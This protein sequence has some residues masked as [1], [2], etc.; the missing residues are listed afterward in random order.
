MGGT[1]VRGFAI[2][3]AAAGGWGLCVS[4]GARGII[5]YVGVLYRGSRLVRTI[6][7]IRQTISAG[8]SL[9]TLRNVLLG[10]R[11]GGLCLTNFSVRLKVSAAVPTA[12]QRPNRVILSTHVFNS[13]IHGVPNRR[14]SVITSGG[15]G[16]VVHDSIARFTVVNVATTSCPS[17]PGMR[18]NIDFTVSRTILGDVVQRAVFTITTPASPHPVCANAGFRVRPSYLQLIDIS[19]CHLT[20]HYRPVG[21]STALSFIMPKGALRRVLGLLG[22][23]RGPYSLVINHQRVV[24]RVSNC[25][26]VSHLLSKRFVTCSG[27]VDP[28]I[29]SAICIGTHTFASTISHISLIVGSHLGSPLIYRFQRSDVD[30]DY[31]APLNSTGSDVFTGVRKRGRSVNF[32]SHFLLS[33][34]GCDRSS[35]IHV[36]LTNTL[37]PVG[38]L[39]GR[40]GDFLFLILPIELGG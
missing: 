38:V 21:G 28:S 15:C 10:T 35:R 6:N 18:S 1:G 40:N 39:P 19:N 3:A 2:P 33:T 30:I 16:A 12:I 14:L 26:I 27:V 24:F 20:V 9:P 29:A 37:G 36:R 11:K 13:V 34:L 4:G 23:R 25:T 17:V 22:S 8:T 31:S 32:G 7:G 5:A